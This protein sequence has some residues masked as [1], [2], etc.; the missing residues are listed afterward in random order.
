[1]AASTTATPDASNNPCLPLPPITGRVAVAF[2]G[3][4]D[5]TALLLAACEAYPDRV[6]AIHINHQLQA[7]AADFEVHCATTCRA[8]AV[9]LEVRRVTVA[10]GPRQSLEA[11][12][13][14]I[15]YDTLAAVA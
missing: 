11:Q 3:G 4:A 2:S 10:C 9:P 8:L 12:A 15:R 5:S 6:V 14:A 7:A 1:M 13:R